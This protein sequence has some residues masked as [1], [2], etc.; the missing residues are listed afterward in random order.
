MAETRAIELYRRMLRVRGFEEEVARRF[1]HG[2]LPGFVH[3]SIGQE[4]VSVGV[5]SVLDREDQITTTHRGHG[6]VVAKGASLRKLAAELYGSP[7]G[8]CRGLGGSM[9]LVDI[10][11]GILCAGA[12]VGGTIPLATG[13]AFSFRQ[14]GVPQVAVSFFGDGATSQGV[15]HECLNLAGL[16]KLPIVYVCEN[17]GYAEMTPTGVHTTVTRLSDYGL[18]YGIPSVTVDGNDVEAVRASAETAVER[19]RRGD[20][21]SLIECRTYRVSGHFEGDPQKYKPAGE[22]ESWKGRDPIRTFG[23]R[24]VARGE[25]TAAELEAAGGEVRSEIESAFAELTSETHL[26]TAD[27]E[28][29]TF[30]DPF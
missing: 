12:I 10:D 18:V 30:A 27:L 9:H 15:F 1:R 3:L 4:A 8:A 22:A 28:S 5:C 23:D 25:A 6:H 14:R 7:D 29:L 26:G 13:V 19:A 24:L 16:W 2:Q 17:N 20:G 21:P 11:Q